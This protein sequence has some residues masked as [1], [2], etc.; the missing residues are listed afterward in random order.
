MNIQISSDTWFNTASLF[1]TD[2]IRFGKTNGNLSG[3][4]IDPATDHKTN[5]ETFLS[6][7]VYTDGQKWSQGSRIIE[8]SLSS[9]NQSQSSTSAN[10]TNSF[11]T[12]EMKTAHTE[13]QSSSLINSILA[14]LGIGTNI[15]ITA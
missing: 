15:N 10:S 3:A 8:T 14:E 2:K 12:Q 11:Q 5:L 7:N 9:L 1:Q 6:R 13:K 4:T